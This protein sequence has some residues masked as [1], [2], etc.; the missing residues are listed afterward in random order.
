MLH[1][2]I[3]MLVV[4]AVLHEVR[5]GRAHVVTGVVVGS[6]EGHRKKGFLLGGL[7]L[8]IHGFEEVGDPVV[9]KDAAVEDI[10]GGIDGGGSTQ[11]FK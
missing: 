4:E 2:R 6:A 5:V 3:K 8:H 10:D 1:D 9:R 11:L 7:T